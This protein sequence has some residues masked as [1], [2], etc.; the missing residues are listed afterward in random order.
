MRRDAYIQLFEAAWAGDLEKIKSLTLHAWGEDPQQREPPLKIT[1]E[2]Y[3]NNTPFSL[4]FYRGWY[5]AAW[6]ILE[7]AQAQYSPPTKKN[8][9]YQLGMGGDP[10]S[11]SESDGG[12]HEPRVVSKTLDD[13]FTVDNVGEVSML[14]KSNVTAFD[15]LHWNT[16]AFGLKNGVPDFGCC[17]IWRPWEFLRRIGDEEMTALGRFMDMGTHFAWRKSEAVPGLDRVS[18]APDESE[19]RQF[20]ERGNVKMLKEVIRRTGAGLPLDEFVK[21]SGVEVKTRPRQY[22]GLS[23]RGRKMYVLIPL[24]IILLSRIPNLCFFVSTGRLGLPPDETCTSSPW[25]SRRP[26]FCTLPST[27][28]V[29]WWSGS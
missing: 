11:D 26:P 2:D 27:A 9:L 13:N 6:G 20:V 12:N 10:D 3:D 16:R 7:I 25:D 29:R 23:V 21:K 17:F 8:K 15:F 19:F 24:M 18:S 5:E 14:V 28:S 22:E 1:V 4:A